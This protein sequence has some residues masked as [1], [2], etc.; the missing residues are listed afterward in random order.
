[1]TMAKKGRK[2]LY[3]IDPEVVPRILQALS[4]GVSIR[5][6]C[7]YIG[8]NEVTYYRWC[9]HDPTFLQET[10]RARVAGRVSAA[11]VVRRSALGD[12]AQGI[13]PN[14]EDAKWYL[15]RTD[16]VTWGR[17]EMLIA[18]GLDAQQLR[19]LKKQADSA[20]VQ[21]SELFESMI[22]E[23]ALLEPPKPRSE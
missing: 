22:Q 17:K 16:P 3:E 20:G 1:M 11:A 8:I 10:Q 7:A 14:T 9:Q 6:V 12:A 15:E 13:A 2:P 5:D 4:T 23:F 21:L 18:L 19:E